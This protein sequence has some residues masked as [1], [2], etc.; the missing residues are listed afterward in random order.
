M[1]RPQDKTYWFGRTFREF[2]RL[3]E[4]FRGQPITYVEIGVWMADSA[5]WMCEEILTHPQARAW[6]IDPYEAD[7]KRGSNEPVRMEAVERM[8]KFPQW[9]WMFSKSQDALRQWSGPQIDLLYID[10]SHFAHDV[11]ADWCYAWPLL[12][13]GSL[14]IFDDYG[15]SKRKTDGHPRVDI[16]VAGIE[17]AFAPFIER[18][19]VF[20]LQAAF[21]VTKEPRVGVGN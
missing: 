21:R 16:A 20:Q 6:G 19:G 5:A 9:S 4:P 14:V 11:M 15:L 8:A 17:A 12:K 13:R 7:F 3:V 10:G 1:I 2:S 18:E